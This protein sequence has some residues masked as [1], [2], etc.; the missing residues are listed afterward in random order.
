MIVHLD[1]SK[2]DAYVAQPGVALL[3][4]RSPDKPVSRIFDAGYANVSARHPDVS[5]ADVDASSDPAFTASWAVPGAPELM[6]YR[7]GTLVFDYPGALPEQVID[8][9]ID[10]IWSLDMDRIR[11]S[12]N[13]HGSRLY[14]AIQP[15]GL[16]RFELGGGGGG[17]S[18]RTPTGQSA[19]H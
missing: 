7:D 14:I 8:A 13:G 19:K 17:G 18:S 16:A 11:Q 5:F 15:S 6:A 1:Q 4:W 3:N 12:T 2:I 10:A 9:L